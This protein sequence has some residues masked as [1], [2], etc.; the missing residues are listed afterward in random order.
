MKN[1]T[2][3]WVTTVKKILHNLDKPPASSETMNACTVYRLLFFCSLTIPLWCIKENSP[4]QEAGVGEGQGTA[5]EEEE[6]KKQKRG[7]V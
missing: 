7:K 5:G 6:K 3:K 1:K 2:A 4:K